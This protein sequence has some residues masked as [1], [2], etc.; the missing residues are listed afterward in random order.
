MF[1]IIIPILF[2]LFTP[3][4][5]CWLWSRVNKF[6]NDK[7]NRKFLFDVYTDFEKG[8]I[9]SQTPKDVETALRQKGTVGHHRETLLKNYR[10]LYNWIIAYRICISVIVILWIAYVIADI[11]V[12]NWS[13][14]ELCVML[15]I[16]TGIYIFG[17]GLPPIFKSSGNLCLKNAAIKVD[18][19]M[20]YL[21]DADGKISSTLLEVAY[22]GIMLI[23]NMLIFW[24][25]LKG[26]AFLF[27][28]FTL[29]SNLINI[30]L[31]LSAY[32]YFTVNCIFVPITYFVFRKVDKL[33]EH[34]NLT[35]FNFSKSYIKDTLINNT[36][37]AFLL[38][39]ISGKSL[40]ADSA[41]IVGI[42]IE[43]I[44][45][46]YLFD[47]FFKNRENAQLKRLAEKES[48]GNQSEDAPYPGSQRV[49]QG[50]HIQ[51]QRQKQNKGIYT[52]FQNNMNNSASYH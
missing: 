1:E 17:L 7:E 30:L 28:V 20:Y 8:I 11:F 42:T 46:V 44:G 25:F 23:A 32:R 27:N 36:Y 47:T 35:Q 18:K 26:G 37:L 34:K 6:N 38:I 2:F 13:Q 12:C 29:E 21:F 43:A 4:V 9:P 50:Q 33:L 10:H 39:Y 52:D 14:P 51:H 49:Q 40:F 5:I 22:T 45:I 31:L 3:A 16:G 41:S 15:V 48:D 24:G 19:F